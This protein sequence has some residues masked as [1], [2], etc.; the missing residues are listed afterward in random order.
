MPTVADQGK[1]A[2]GQLINDLQD[3]SFL[4]IGVIVVGVWLAI[5]VTRKVLPYLANRGPSQF[6]LYLLG[7]VPIIRLVLLVL[8]IL[9][10][11]PII[12]N[13]T[14]QNF[15]VIAGAA[16]VAIGFAFKD[17]ISSLIAGVVAIIER[18]YRPG[19]WVKIDGDYGEVISVGMRSIRVLTAAANTITI[20]HERI[21]TQ[22][23]SNANDGARTLM[24]V[25]H[26]YL[27]PQHDAARVREVLKD[28]AV[29]SAYLNYEQPVLV[30][31]A[32]TPW[33]THY[34]LKAYPY[35][36]RDQFAFISDLTVRG[37]IAIAQAGGREVSASALPGS[38]D[39]NIPTL[40]AFG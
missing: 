30:T 28:V 14:L 6:R 33:A 17:Y 36:L 2:A 11:V 13:I 38:A 39:G 31:L 21:W 4:E 37:K 3:I 12:F 23:I 40:D 19:D 9:W 10:V 22:N 34:Q 16:G 18:P 26:F 29:T 24:C 1:K 15:L 5:Y 20:P 25:A 8:A 35:D 7:A 27:A 32:E